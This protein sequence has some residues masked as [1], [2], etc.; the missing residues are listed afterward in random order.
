[1]PRTLPPVLV[2]YTEV[3][4]TTTAATLASA[5]VAWQTGDII[6][7]MAADESTSATLALPTA[8]GLTFATQRSNTAASSCGM[9]DATA[10]AGSAGSSVVTVVKGTSTHMGGFGVWVWRSSDGVGVSVEQHTT[11][12]TVALEPSD[13]HS[14]FY[15]SIADFSAQAITDALTPP[16][17]T[18]QEAAQESVSTYSV[19]SGNL[20]DL[21]LVA[22]QNFGIIGT[23]V[24]GPYTI[25]VQEILGST[26][27]A[28]PIQYT[29]SRMRYRGL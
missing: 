17:T 20:N 19:Y 27:Q 22:S 21:S 13:R 9:L 3:A 24:G 18:T 12:K 11:T 1:M 8:T 7:V 25:I 29:L 16:A 14:A 4:Y 28:S 2:S 5:S 6:S 26:D 15:W 23:T 10:V